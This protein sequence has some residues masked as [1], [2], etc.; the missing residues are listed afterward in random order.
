MCFISFQCS[1]VK[2][3]DP[4]QAQALFTG[5]EIL[6]WK[7]AVQSRIYGA[8]KKNSLNVNFQCNTLDQQIGGKNYFA[9]ED[10]KDE[11]LVATFTEMSSKEGHTT[12]RGEQERRLQ[13]A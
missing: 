7:E 2:V 5:E 12:D 11:R 10:Q 6:F 13:T 9:T 8:R 3:D 1:Q 4:G